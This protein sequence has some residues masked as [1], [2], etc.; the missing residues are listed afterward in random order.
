MSK[1]DRNWGNKPLST[2]TA[3]IIILMFVLGFLGG[4][5]FALTFG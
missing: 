2:K 1:N 4:L 5:L 3:S